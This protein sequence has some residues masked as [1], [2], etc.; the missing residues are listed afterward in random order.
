MGRRKTKSMSQRAVPE[1]VRVPSIPAAPKRQFKLVFHNKRCSISYGN[2]NYSVRMS[3]NT[4]KTGEK[5]FRITFANGAVQFFPVGYFANVMT[6]IYDPDR[7]YLVVSNEKSP[8]CQFKVSS[9]S[10][11][12]TGA[13]TTTMFA[14]KITS[15]SEL[16]V[17]ALEK[18]VG[19][20]PRIIQD[21]MGGYFF[22]DINDKEEI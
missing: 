10:K 21:S 4:T 1:K 16:D 7:L 18:F 13:V 6:D 12:N 17:E 14:P 15:D 8:S 20:Y 5:S 2:H 9:R 19:C 3:I 11:R 22:I